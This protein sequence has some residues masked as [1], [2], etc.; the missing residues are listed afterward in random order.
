MNTPLSA[1]RA[2]LSARLPAPPPQA[3]A[4]VARSGFVAHYLGATLP[5]AELAAGCRLAGQDS[6]GAAL[7][8]TVTEAEP[9][10]SLALRLRGAQGAQ[11]LRLSL[12]ACASGSRLTVLHEADAEASSPATG[13]EAAAGDPVARLLAAAPAA[14][15]T[16][17]RIGTAQALD[18]ACRYLADSAQAVRL[19]LAAMGPRQGYRKPASGT[20]SLVEHLWHLADVEQLGWSRRWPRV[21]AEAAPRLPGVDGDR[22]A[23]LHRYQ[24]RPWRAAAR[25]FIAQRQRSLKALARLDEAALARPLWFGG[26]RVDAGTLLAAML[27]HD[28]EHR[29]EMAARWHEEGPHR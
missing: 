9:P 15:L 6:A 11:V 17:P 22:L 13:G 10:C 26:R 28:H 2:V 19:L 21:L 8:L 18:L 16:A 29:T 4:L 5:P 27:A 12:Q 25:R 24:Q 20:F 3:W 14:A 1:P 23:I 7:Q